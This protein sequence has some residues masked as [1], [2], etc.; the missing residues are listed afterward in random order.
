MFY[1]PIKI[2]VINNCILLIVFR[3]IKIW[4]DYYRYGFNHKTIF[5]KMGLKIKR[6]LNEINTLSSLWH[7]F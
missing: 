4:K 6:I 3:F 1:T 5:W 7:Y 2:T